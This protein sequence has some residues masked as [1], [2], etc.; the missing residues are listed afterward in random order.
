MKEMDRRT[1]WLKNAHTVEDVYGSH[2]DYVEEI[3]VCPECGEPIYL[4]DWQTQD[5]ENFLCPVCEWNGEE[6]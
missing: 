3:Y 2:V 4:E 6:E 1:A 5:L